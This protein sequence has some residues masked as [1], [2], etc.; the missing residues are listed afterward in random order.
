MTFSEK[1]ATFGHKIFGFYFLNIL[2]IRVFEMIKETYPEN[3]K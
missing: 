3:L 2:T 1:K